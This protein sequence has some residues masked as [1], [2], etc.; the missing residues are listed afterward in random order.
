MS[1]F[2]AR[3]SSQTGEPALPYQVVKT[4]VPPGA[5]LSTIEVSVKRTTVESNSVESQDAWEVRPTP[6]PTVNPEDEPVLNEQGQ[7]EEIYATN[8][9]FP[10]TLV[11]N[12]V[13][14]GNLWGWQ[15][16]DIPIA[17]FQYNPVAKSLY[18]LDA[19]EAVITFEHQSSLKRSDISSYPV[20]N[21]ERVKGLVVN[22]DEVSP[23]Y[24][25][26]DKKR[27]ASRKS[28]VILTTNAIRSGSAQLDNFIQTKEA[29]GFT[30][31]VITD[32]IWG[33]G[34]GDS[35]AEN[36]RNWLKNNYV[37]LNIEYVLLIGNPHPDTGDVPMKMLWPRSRYYDEHRDSPSDYYYADLTG[38]WDLDRDGKYGEWEDDFGAGGVDR[39]YEVMVGRIPYYGNMTDLDSILAKIV[40]YQNESDQNWRKNVLLPMEQSDD[41]TPGYHL[42]EAIK[43]DIIAPKGWSY[44]RIY[45]DTFGLTPAP[46][47]LSDCPL[48]P[49]WLA[50]CNCGCDKITSAWNSDDFGAVFWWTH[51]G[52]TDAYSVMDAS[53][54][55]TLDNAHPGFVFQCSC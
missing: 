13:S 32:N 8:A 42:G 29:R 38:N 14:T 39:N 23:Q 51:G 31:R 41:A 10:A 45:H 50:S 35:A 15:L 25:T 21:K 40:S 3:G 16:V 53:H 43:N 22:F 11:H 1:V 52:S 2:P 7:D 37:S 34:K 54:A 33:G 36:I 6:V 26:L 20:F 28:Y 18:S 55:E 4:L 24:T 47:T 19:K 46:E 49:P 48:P 30:V 17:L 12:N 27:D 9:R 44:H 5:D